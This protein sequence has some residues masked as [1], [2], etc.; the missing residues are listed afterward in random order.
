[1][2]IDHKLYWM[3]VSTDEEA[4][5]LSA[6]LNSETA[7]SRVE[8][9]QSE[10]QFGPRDFDKVMFSL[11]IPLFDKAN[12][13]H[14]R[15][16]VAAQDAEKIASTVDISDCRGFQAVR[17]LIRKSLQDVGILDQIDVLVSDLLRAPT[18]RH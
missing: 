13:L 1:M 11:A 5:F 3:A 2:I 18:K 12:Q 14:A 9:L 17:R 8:G 16:T 7:R 6:I 10:G 15:L 4:Q